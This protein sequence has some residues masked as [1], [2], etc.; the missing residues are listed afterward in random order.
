MVIRGKLISGVY[1]CQDVYFDPRHALKV[2][3]KQEWYDK[4]RHKES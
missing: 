4:R 3:G 2:V 1:C